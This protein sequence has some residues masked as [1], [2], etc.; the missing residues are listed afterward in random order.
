MLGLGSLDLN[1]PLIND[2]EP[3]CLL[4]E[5]EGHFTCPSVYSCALAYLIGSTVSHCSPGWWPQC[6]EPEYKEACSE[7]LTR[8]ALGRDTNTSPDWTYG[9]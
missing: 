1:D 4:N 6:L 7:Q 2:S 8:M 5:T 3:V 9:S